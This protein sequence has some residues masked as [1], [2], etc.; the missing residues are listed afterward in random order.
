[1]VRLL[2]SMVND[3]QK[4]NISSGVHMR[5]VGIENN[6]YNNVIALS[7]VV[8]GSVMVLKVINEKET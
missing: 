6:Y 8:L 3:C 2:L 7:M 1:M 5:K 4:N